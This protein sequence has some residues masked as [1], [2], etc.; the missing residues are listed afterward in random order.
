MGWGLG[1]GGGDNDIKLTGLCLMKTGEMETYPCIAVRDSCA[2]E[3][4]LGGQIL[5]EITRYQLTPL[6]CLLLRG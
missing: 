1:G 4:Q 2:K 3:R 5:G 6:P